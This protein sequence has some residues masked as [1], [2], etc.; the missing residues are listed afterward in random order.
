MTYYIYLTKKKDEKKKKRK[1]NE[2]TCSND[3]IETKP[4]RTCK[5]RPNITSKDEIRKFDLISGSGNGKILRLRRKS[6]YHLH[7]KISRST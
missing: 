3:E 4:M 1:K 5:Q 2:M 6:K 7:N